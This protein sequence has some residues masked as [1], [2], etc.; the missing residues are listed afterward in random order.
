M[1]FCYILMFPCKG[2]PSITRG[3]RS[4]HKSP[5]NAHMTIGTAPPREKRTTQN[6]VR[7]RKFGKEEMF[8][9]TE[10]KE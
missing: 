2:L 9:R 1:G 10:K 3:K 8:L 6:A 5:L 4:R 7:D